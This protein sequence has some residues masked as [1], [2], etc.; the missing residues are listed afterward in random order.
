MT[1]LK[2]LLIPLLSVASIAQLTGCTTI[3]SNNNRVALSNISPA[4]QTE[5]A[6]D[7]VSQ[8]SQKALLAQQVLTK[9]RQTYSE[10]MDYRQRS[11]ETDR[12]LIDYIGRPQTALA[13]IS[14]KYG[15]R[16]IEQ[17]KNHDL[18]VINFTQYYAT[19]EQIVVSIDAQLGG[20]A[21][22]SVD[23]HNKVITLI[24]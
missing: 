12:V 3:A 8:E 7:I 17:G 10:T 2:F 24:Y 15:Y 23:K 11:F 14:I 16:F 6:L 1:T 9:Y 21:K 22:I 19:P 18:P 4:Y 5:S 20:A 13:S